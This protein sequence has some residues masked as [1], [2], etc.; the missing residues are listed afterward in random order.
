MRVYRQ[1]QPL[2]AVCDGTGHYEGHPNLDCVTL[3][4]LLQR[5][6]L[7]FGRASSEARRGALLGKLTLLRIW[8]RTAELHV[9]QGKMANTHAFS[10]LRNVIDQAFDISSGEKTRQG[11]LHRYQRAKNNDPRITC[12][13]HTHTAYSARQAHELQRQLLRLKP[14]IGIPRPVAYV[15]LTTLYMWRI[16]VELSLTQDNTIPMSWSLHAGNAILI[17]SLL[18]LFVSVGSDCCA[19][20]RFPHD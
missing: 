2:C 8:P 19:S 7:R 3:R 4:A 5:V 6:E 1:G 9:K 20:E 15:N 17:F 18:R 10:I 13:T 11:S 16:L 14:S 12:D